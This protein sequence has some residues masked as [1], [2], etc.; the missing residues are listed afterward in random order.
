[1]LKAYDE[2]LRTD[3]ETS[4]AVSVTRHGPLRLATFDGGRGFISYQDLG[5]AGEAGIEELV[6][7]AVAHFDADPGITEVEWKTR[8][9][10]HAPG[11]HDALLRHGFAPDEPESIMVGEARLLAVDVPLPDGVALRTITSVQDVRAAS[12]MQDAVF[13]SP[14]S[15]ARVESQLRGIAAGESEMWVAE[16]DGEV[17]SAGR[18]DMVPGTEF[19][20]I[21]GGAT[22]EKWRGRGIYRALTA[23]RARTAIDRGKRYIHSDSTEFSRPI[24]E[25]S[26]LVKVGTTTPYVRRRSRGSG[27]D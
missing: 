15:E 22:L 3:A 10:D 12:I 14:A 24:L 19:A 5:G 23:A 26:G 2:Q 27:S 16:A 1:M 4:G 13:G 6:A 7:A 18:I 9:H 17:L 21:W 20:G 11:L 8:G 25:R